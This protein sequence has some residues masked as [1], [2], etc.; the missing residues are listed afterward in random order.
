MIFDRLLYPSNSLIL[1]NDYIP[2]DTYDDW[3]K[4]LDEVGK[5]Y[6][7]RKLSDLVADDRPQLGGAAVVFTSP[8]KKNFLRAIPELVARGIPVTLFLRP[9]CIGLNRLPPEEE[10]R[11]F[12]FS[13]IEQ[14]FYKP[15]ETEAFLLCLRK[16]K[17]A[18][19]VEELDPTLFFATWGKVLEIP[20]ELRDFGFYVYARPDHDALITE[21]LRFTETQTVQRMTL[22]FS[23]QTLSPREKAK[24]R[25]KKIRALLTSREGIIE[26]TTDIWDL[27]RFSERI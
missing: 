10:L 5:Y 8:R 24:L 11:Y 3:L 23:P 20:P 13:D 18:L 4:Q 9:D 2:D 17:G 6:R 21:A 22:A 12:G 16:E 7:W 15:E 19:P 26:K 27:P 14:A 1:A 25:D